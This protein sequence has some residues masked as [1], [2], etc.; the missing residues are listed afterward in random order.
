M[1]KILLINL[2]SFSSLALSQVVTA[3]SSCSL[4]SIQN[5]SYASA[6][7]YSA[8]SNKSNSVTY[9][10]IYYGDGTSETVPILPDE[11]VVQEPQVVQQVTPQP[12]INDES[13]EFLPPTDQ[14]SNFVP[15]PVISKSKSNVPDF[16]EFR[17][18]GSNNALSAPHSPYVNSLNGVSI[19]TGR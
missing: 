13:L 15:P 14:R 6:P 1:K 4:E 9:E 18:N 16:S 5:Y 11:V 3:D 10:T 17:V 12:P 8:P 19:D 7:Y 2:L